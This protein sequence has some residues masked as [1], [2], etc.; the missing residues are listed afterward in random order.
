[1]QRSWPNFRKACEFVRNGYLG[2]IKKVLVNVGD[3]ARDY[4]LIAEPIPAEVDWNKWC[5]PAP[6]L[7]YNHRLAPA[8]NDVKFWPDW[9]LYKEVGGG[10][11][12]DWGAHM[13]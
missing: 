5:G 4:D 3:P 6:M 12:C 9:R 10:I 8:N 2:E 11:L 7:A 1:M 13:F